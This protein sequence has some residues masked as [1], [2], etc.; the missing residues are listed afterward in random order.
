MG[1]RGRVGPA[2]AEAGGLA[3]WRRRGDDL[4]ARR[5]R[6]EAARD[7]GRG[8]RERRADQARGGSRRDG[9]RGGAGGV[10]AQ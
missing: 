8:A 10:A 9:G 1:R 6:G 3:V 2:S 7:G 4:A 5:E